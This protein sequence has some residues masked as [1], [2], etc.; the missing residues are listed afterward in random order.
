MIL[1]DTVLNMYMSV[2]EQNAEI[3]RIQNAPDGELLFI[4]SKYANH[5]KIKTLLYKAGIKY[6]TGFTEYTVHYYK[7]VYRDNYLE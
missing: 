3:K 7:G 5:D 1:S 4:A 6:Y 2:N